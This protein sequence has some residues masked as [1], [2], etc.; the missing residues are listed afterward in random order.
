M[1]T[2]ATLI[3]NNTWL[4][5][6]LILLEL[7]PDEKKNIEGYQKMFNQLQLLS[8]TPSEVIIVVKWETDDFDGAKYVDVS[9][10]YKY[11]N[12]KTEKEQIP[13]AIGFTPWS[14]WLGMEV[15]TESL[16]NFNELE[17]IAHCIYEM[18]FL[19]FDEEVIRARLQNKEPEAEKLK[20]MT[21]E[22]RKENTTSLD[23]L[24]KGFDD[25][26]K[27]LDDE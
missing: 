3:Q 23:D 27:D 9:G 24:F 6:E 20:N 11:N 21:E 16:Q 15:A 1:K 7:Y 26:F 8:P 4:S 10:K 14:E 12:S 22:E 17:I 13:L 19:G 5:T 18:C 2:F 25:L